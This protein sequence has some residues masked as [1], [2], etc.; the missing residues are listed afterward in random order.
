M[1]AIEGRRWFEKAKQ[2][3]KATIDTAL[4]AMVAFSKPFINPLLA[5]AIFPQISNLV[6]KISIPHSLGKCGALSLLI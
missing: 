4:I 3:L 6:G 2:A 1:K 5:F